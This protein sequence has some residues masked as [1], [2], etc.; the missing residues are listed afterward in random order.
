MVWVHNYNVNLTEI[1]AYFYV[2]SLMAYFMSAVIWLQYMFKCVI[3]ED[4]DVLCASWEYV[5]DVA[6]VL[7]VM[8]EGGVLGHY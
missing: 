7:M 2:R 8:V 4:H 5:L 3:S 6:G 1:K